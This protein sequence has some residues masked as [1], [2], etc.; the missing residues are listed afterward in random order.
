MSRKAAVKKSKAPKKAAKKPM[1]KRV[2]KPVASKNKTEP[3]RSASNPFRPTSSYAAVY[4]ILVAHPSG[5]AR[6]KLV[7]LAA[8]ATGKSAKRAGF[9]V[10]V[11]L[12]AKDS[13]TGKR[14]RSCREG[15]W[16]E[17]ENDHVKL[18]TA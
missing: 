14:H 6:P 15:F 2:T 4:E 8:A 11:L 3:V 13:P 1:T 9:D 16:I 18:R 10:A 5:I 7:E 17:R 12:S